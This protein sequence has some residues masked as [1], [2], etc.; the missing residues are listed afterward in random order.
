MTSIIDTSDGTA[1]SMNSNERHTHPDRNRKSSSELVIKRRL[2]SAAAEGSTNVDVDVSQNGRTCWRHEEKMIKRCGN[3][4]RVHRRHEQQAKQQWSSERCVGLCIKPGKKMK[5]CSSDAC[6]NNIVKGGVCVR[7]GAHIKRRVGKDAQIKLV[8]EE[9][10]LSTGHGRMFIPKRCSR[11]GF[12]T[13]TVLGMGHGR[14]FIPKRCSPVGFTNKLVEKLNARSK[15]CEV[16]KDAQIN[17]KKEECALD[18]G[19]RSHANDAAAKNVQIKPKK[20][21]F[22]R[23]TGPIACEDS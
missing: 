20:E 7:S 12:T 6:T 10:V 8:R 14:M 21:E 15:M 1:G 17:P 9:R 22:V 2:C 3:E 16:L 4:G 13:A 11:V 19:L 23:G 18:M 5:A